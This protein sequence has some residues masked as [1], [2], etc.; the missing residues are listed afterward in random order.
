MGMHIC[1]IL[2]MYMYIV[3]IHIPN[4][5]SSPYMSYLIPAE[6]GPGVYAILKGKVVKF[7]ITSESVTLGRNYCRTGGL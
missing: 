4:V 3:Y 7:M 5:V 6:F 2:Y 1:I